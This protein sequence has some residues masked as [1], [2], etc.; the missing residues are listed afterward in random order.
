MASHASGQFS[1]QGDAQAVEFVARNTT[2]GA[3]T[4]DL[5]LDGGTAPQRITIPVDSC[6]SGFVTVSGI[7]T[8]GAENVVTQRN[9]FISNVAGTVTLNHDGAVC[10]NHKSNV[11]LTVALSADNAN[12]ALQIACTGIAGVTMRWV[13]VLRLTEIRF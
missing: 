5:Y 6:L 2:S 1:V 7:S 11:G 4:A 3:T 12:Q 9:I 10:P 8:N 13:A